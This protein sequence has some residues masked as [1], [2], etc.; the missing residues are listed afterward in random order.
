MKQYLRQKVNTDDFNLVSVID[1]LP[2]WSAP[3]GLKLL[4]TIRM[5]KDMKVLDIGCGT[6]F[7][8]IEIAERLGNSGEVFGIDPWPRA[9]ERV[10]LK[11]QVYDIKNVVVRNGCAEDMPFEDN[12]FDLIVSNNGLNNVSDLSRSIKECF[13]VAKGNAQMT[14]TMNSDE[15]M[16]EFYAVFQDCLKNNGLHEKIQKMKEQIYSK[17]KPLQEITDI[18]KA[19]GFKAVNIQEDSFKIR[20]LDGTTML[21]HYLIKFW[22]LPGWKNILNN[23][24]A[25]KIFD[26]AEGKLNNLAEKKGELVLTVPFVTVDCRKH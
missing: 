17:R 7:P 13:R 25:V 19:T 23:N 16:I 21:N 12:F 22:F 20:F 15:T 11:L 26:E 4:D 8:L 9:L 3:F 14:F 5:H 10:R 6:G 2:L 18:L 1:D 24:Q